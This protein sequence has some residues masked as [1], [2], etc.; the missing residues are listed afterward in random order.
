MGLIVRK[1]L[2][3]NL[4]ATTNPT[5]NDDASNGYSKLSS[6]I[7]N[8]T[9][10]YECADATAGAAIWKD[11]SSAGGGGGTGDVVGPA[12]STDNALARYD[13]TTGKLLQNSGATLDDLGNITANNLSGSNTGDQIA[14]GIPNTPSGSITS[15]NVQDAIDELNVDKQAQN[16]TLQ[17]ISDLGSNEAPILY[18][19]AWTPS[20]NTPTLADGSSSN[21]GHLYTVLSAGTADLGSGSVTYRA[22]DYILAN[23]VGNY[24]QMANVKTA[25]DL[26]NV[27]AGNITATDVQGA[28]NELDAEK[29]S[30]TL[31]DAEIFVGDGSNVATSVAMSGDATIANTGAV[32]IANEA[33]SNSKLA[34]VSTAT[35]KGRVSAGTGDIED[36][37]GTQATTILDNVVGDTGS[38]GIKGLVPAPASGDAASSKFLKADGTWAVISGSG[39]V[40]GPASSTDNA[41][42]RF[43]GTTGK[44]LQNSGASLDDSG[45][46]TA[47]NLSGTNTG[48]QTTITGNAGTATALETAR[49][50]GGTSF[51]GTANIAIGSLNITNVASTTSAELAGLISD[52]TG[53]GSLVFGTSPTLVTPALGTPSALV[54]TNVTGTASGLT[55]GT[56]TTNANLTGDVTSIGNATTLTNAP[57]IAKVLTGYTKGAGTVASTDS[58]LQAIQKLDGNDDAKLGT[59]LTDS[60]I[61]VGNGSNLATGVTI[62]GDATIANT[63]T[64]TISSDAVTYDKM[65]DTSSTD[66]IL[67]RSTAGS[68]TVEEITC[69]SAGRALLDDSSASDQRTT[70]GLVIGTDVQAYDANTA[71]TDVAQEY[72]ATQNFNATTLTDAATINWDASANQ[73]C[74]VTLAGNR[75]MAAPTNLKDGATYILRIIQDATGTRTITWNTVFKWAGGTAPTLSTGGG[76]IDIITFVSDGTN[77]YGCSQLNFS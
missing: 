41:L 31:T 45:N 77:L 69:T 35:F 30:K 24:K 1:D 39:D 52:K 27:T 16:D 29:L 55:A 37:T 19:G 7:V 43:D 67:G 46:L 11:I 62:S 60:Q 51:D 76:A 50:I 26:P 12:S 75:T 5:V 54:A 4:T 48:D 36:L 64:V 65:Q 21:Q 9:T 8:D 23:P 58:I 10:I 38:G 28:I 47:N 22:G 18:K 14:S 25:A 3:N 33:I 56:V 49:T 72:T 17:E 74:K 70:L 13:G 15:T 61:F 40:V 73:V 63:G 20:T 34:N 59:S 68:G 71:K 42:A 57:V 66:V 6:W 32:T 44:I 2:K 53:S